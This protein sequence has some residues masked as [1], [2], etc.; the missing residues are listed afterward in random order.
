MSPWTD[1][2]AR[3]GEDHR[4]DVTL[5]DAIALVGWSLLG[6]P[7][8][9]V[10]LGTVVRA[11]GGDVS[12]FASPPAS[13]VLLVIVQSGVLAG[14]LAWLAGR[15]RLTWRLLGS[16]RTSARHLAQGVAAGLLAVAVAV[17]VALA[18]TAITGSEDSSGQSLLDPS[19]TEGFGLWVVLLG[20]G[21]LAPVTEELIFR[22]ALF[23]TIGRRIGWVPGLVVSSLVFAVV[24]IEVVIS[25]GNA[26]VFLTALAAVGAVFAATF[27]RTRNLVAAMVAHGT[28]NTVQLLLSR[29][30]VG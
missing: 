8:I 14:A 18:G 4:I 26:V 27:H 30:D 19:L 17:A 29:L 25:G 23:Q 9:A 11:T 21:V 10:L 1:P 6:A 2:D 3:P 13:V 22:G 28:F 16:Q 7:L 5:L 15:R 24:H 12:G 20:V